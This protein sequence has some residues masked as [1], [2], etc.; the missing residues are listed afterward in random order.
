MHIQLGFV[1]GMRDICAIPLA[2]LE[3]EYAK[4]HHMVGP[5]L[6]QYCSLG[7]EPV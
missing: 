4:I 7:T 3:E 6:T 2:T 5:S 1:R